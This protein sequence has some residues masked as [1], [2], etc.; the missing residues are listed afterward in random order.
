MRI[1]GDHGQRGDFRAVLV[2]VVDTPETHRTILHRDV[3]FILLFMVFIVFIV[4]IVCMRHTRRE[5]YAD[6]QPQTTPKSQIRKLHGPRCA[7]ALGCGVVVC[8]TCNVFWNWVACLRRYSV[9]IGN[10]MHA[11]VKLVTF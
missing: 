11:R 7:A 5:V 3:L 2:V 1:P 4:F 8:T 6:E 10:L 9:Y